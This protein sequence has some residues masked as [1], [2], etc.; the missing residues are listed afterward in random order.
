MY[1]ITQTGRTLAVALVLAAGMFAQAGAQAIQVDARF[2]SAAIMIGDQ[3]KLRIELERQK[4]VSVQFPAW[5]D[6]LTR[7][8]EI[9]EVYPVDSAQAPGGMVR[10]M[11]NITITSF[12]SGRHVLPPLRF[13]FTAEGKSDTIVTRPA[14]LDVRVMPMDTTQN[15]ADIKPVY[16]V[17]IGWADVWPWLAGFG[18]LLLAA[19]LVGFGIYAFI[20]WRSNKPVFSAPKPAEPPHVIALRELDKL[21]GEKLWQNNRTKDYYTRLSDIV[22]TYIEGRFDVPAMEMTS[23]EILD[24]LRATGFEDNNLVNCLRKLFALADLVKFAKSEPLPD[25]NETSILDSYLFVNNT[26]I[27]IIAEVIESDSSEKKEEVIQTI[28]PADN[29]TGKVQHFFLNLLKRISFAN[30]WKH[31][32]CFSLICVAILQIVIVPENFDIGKVGGWG[33]YFFYGV[34]LLVWILNIWAYS[35][36]FYNIRLY[37]DIF[38]LTFLYHTSF[39]ML[40]FIE[41]VVR[42]VL[43]GSSF[44]VLFFIWMFLLFQLVGILSTLFLSWIMY[45]VKGG[46]TIEYRNHHQPSKTGNQ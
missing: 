17:P 13:P 42:D 10:M 34:L 23:D 2:D 27:E 3:I 20:R 40:V 26:K 1:H 25:E 11:Q 28:A 15:I 45:L 36:I 31:S 30:K 6:T 8:I 9:I 35:K 41:I 32:F 19:A 14:Y 43:S 33:I 5:T 38:K 24:G 21:R 46:K 44:V 22:R 29:S 7:N 18:L 12:D 39:Y 16:T 4:N 37:K